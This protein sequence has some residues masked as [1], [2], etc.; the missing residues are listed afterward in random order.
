MLDPVGISAEPVTFLIYQEQTERKSKRAALSPVSK[1]ANFRSSPGFFA[2]Y[3]TLSLFLRSSPFFPAALTNTRF[4]PRR[5]KRR[6]SQA[7]VFV[8]RR[9]DRWR[10]RKGLG[11]KKTPL[12]NFLPSF[13]LSLPSRVYPSIHIR[14]FSPIVQQFLFPFGVSVG[15]E[16]SRPKLYKKGWLRPTL[17][18]CLIAPTRRLL[19]FSYTLQC[20]LPTHARTWAWLGFV[21]SQ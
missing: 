11:A 16:R 20:I 1:R 17:K 13:F 9:M 6:D 5:R 18:K 8:R 15:E 19:P 21:Q 7:S 10:G 12:M 3:F 4:W 2:R 14:G